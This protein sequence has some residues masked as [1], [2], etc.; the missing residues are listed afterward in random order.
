MEW[1]TRVLS[2]MLCTLKGYDAQGYPLEGVDVVPDK[3]PPGKWLPPYSKEEDTIPALVQ[4][5]QDA[6]KRETRL[7][8]SV[9]YWNQ[10]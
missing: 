7:K 9:D 6:N 3:K 2:G 5:L 1:L 8:D 10:K 4:L